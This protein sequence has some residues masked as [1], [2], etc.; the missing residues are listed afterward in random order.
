MKKRICITLCGV[1]LVAIVGANISGTGWIFYHDGPYKGKVVDADTGEPIEGAAVL[2]EWPL[3]TYG[4]AAGPVQIYCDAQE[5]LTDKNGEFTVPKAFCFNFWPFSKMGIA[6]FVIFKPGF[7]SYPPSLLVIKHPFTKKDEEE[8]Y[9]Y[10]SEYLVK[11]EKS[12]ENRIRLKKTKNNEEREWI[13]THI[14]LTDIPDSKRPKKAKQIIKLIN[15]ES[16][17]LG[18]QPGWREEQ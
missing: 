1:F 5:T 16:Q 14:S 13:V 15:K 12:Q 9:K 7:D 3:E 10:R 11:I 4:G 17:L 6:E 2:G 18:L 8:R